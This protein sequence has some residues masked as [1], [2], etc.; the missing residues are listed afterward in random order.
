MIIGHQ[1]ILDFFKKSIKNDRLAHAY[2]FAG[3]ANVGKRTMALELIKMLNGCDITEAMH[4]DALVIEPAVTEK[5]KVK[6]QSEIGISEV[7]KV[8]HQLSLSPYSAPYKIALIDQAEKM[9]DEASNCL[10][11]TLEEP[12]GKSILI[13]ITANQN[14]LLA[15]IISRCQLI[16]FLSVPNNIILKEIQKI[17]QGRMANNNSLNKIIRLSNGRPGLTMRYL[18]DSR[19]LKNQDEIIEQLQKI[20]GSDLNDKYRLAEDMSKDIPQ[21]RHILNCWLFWF[22]DVILSSCNCS[23]L[24]IYP[25]TSNYSNYYSLSKLKKIIQAIRKTRSLLENS[26]FNSRL[27]LEVLMLEL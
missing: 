10:L 9:T 25:Q 26:S 15:T 12:S 17:S 2:L 13:L 19:L 27:A 21:A 14:S 18:Q 3:P 16:K 20:I 8:R 7:R 6:K 4:P 11:K 24:M 1:K 22:R 5:E 23:D